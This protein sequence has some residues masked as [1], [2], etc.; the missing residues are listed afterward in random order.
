MFRLKIKVPLACIWNVLM[1]VVSHDSVTLACFLSTSTTVPASKAHRHSRNRELIVFNARITSHSK[2]HEGVMHILDY[3]NA[4]KTHLS[5]H[6]TIWKQMY[7]GAIFL[8]RLPK[9]EIRS[10]KHWKWRTGTSNRTEK[11]LERCR[12]WFFSFERAQE[13]RKRDRTL[14]STYS[15]SVHFQYLPFEYNGKLL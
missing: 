11:D 15:V 2:M 3:L 1:C 12:K 7:F 6:L 8:S 13:S 10:W 4:D 14:I 9:G 5:W